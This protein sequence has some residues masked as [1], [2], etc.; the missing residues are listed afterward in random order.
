MSKK[1]PRILLWDIE[2]SPILGYVWGK[3]DQTVIDFKDDYYLLSVAWKWLGE[4]TTHVLGLCDFPGYDR[5]RKDDK[6]LCLKIRE[7][8]DEAD[9]TIAHNGDS[10]DTKKAH[11]RMMVHGIDPPSPRLQIDTLKVARRA[12]MFTS[13][14]LGDLGQT[15]GVGAKMDAG[16]INTWLGCMNLK[17]NEQTG[18]LVECTEAER[19]KAWRHMKKYNK[20]DVDLLERVYYKLR[21]W[22]PTHPN[23]SLIYSRPEVCPRCGVEGRMARRGT[24]K[25]MMRLYYQY[26]CGACRGYSTDTRPIPYDEAPRPDYKPS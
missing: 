1:Q 18:T 13:N 9:I 3:Y 11:A 6:A 14:K 5:N 24:R 17:H 20:A 22:A 23:L 7:L 21:P 2:S 26:R 10:F 8:L 19:K 12:A 15:L 25:A 16:G 4:S